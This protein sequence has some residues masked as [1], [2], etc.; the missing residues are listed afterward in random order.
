M[1]L[2]RQIRLDLPQGDPESL[3]FLLDFSELLREALAEKRFEDAAACIRYTVN[4]SC[5]EAFYWAIGTLEETWSQAVDALPDFECV[6]GKSIPDYNEF[7]SRLQVELNAFENDVEPVRDE[8]GE[9]QSFY[10]II[11]YRT[12]FPHIR[13]VTSENFDTRDNDFIE[14]RL[15]CSTN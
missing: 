12:G 9:I 7:I 10:N 5:H 15:I 4:H 1:E 11:S 14:Y 3:E 2:Q 13:L 8:H 6:L